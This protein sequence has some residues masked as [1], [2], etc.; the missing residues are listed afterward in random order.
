MKVYLSKYAGFCPGVKRATGT[1]ESLISKKESNEIICTLG[2]IIHNDL[3]NNS[4]KEKGVLITDIEMI[5]S[6]L[7]NS[8]EKVNVVIRAHGITLSDEIKLNDLAVFCIFCYVSCGSV[9]ESDTDTDNQVAVLL[10]H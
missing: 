9:T 2:P 3:Y 1:V 8:Y 6:L 4:L 5:E 7:L 10:S